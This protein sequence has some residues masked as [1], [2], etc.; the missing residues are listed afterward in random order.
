MV[1]HV[2]YFVGVDAAP[3]RNMAMV[4]RFQDPD[5]V[6]WVKGGQA[7]LCTAEGMYTFCEDPIK[8][9]HLD[10]H[11]KFPRQPC[12]GPCRYVWRLMLIMLLWLFNYDWLLAKHSEH[13]IHY[14]KVQI[15]SM[16]STTSKF[17]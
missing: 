16:S 15:M 1:T 8:R 17:K 10:L 13:V 7:L 12:S 3:V 14:I 5:Y 4:T 2:L 11:R 6:N 9:Y